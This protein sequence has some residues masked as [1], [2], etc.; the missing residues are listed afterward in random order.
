MELT[1]R[2]ELCVHNVNFFLLYFH[3]CIHDI[4]FDIETHASESEISQKKNLNIKVKSRE[5]K[6]DYALDDDVT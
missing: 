3:Y 1:S 6:L 5:G 4:V 2:S